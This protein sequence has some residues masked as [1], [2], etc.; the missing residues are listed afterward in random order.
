MISFIIMYFILAFINYNLF[1]FFNMQFG[2]GENQ[3]KM[4]DNQKE[5]VYIQVSLLW[6]FTLP[7]FIY[8]NYKCR[9]QNDFRF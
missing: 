5:K 4:N 2:S 6:I 3:V 1:K 7:I 9:R 8:N